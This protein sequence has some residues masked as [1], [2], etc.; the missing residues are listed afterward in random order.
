MRPT[1]LH[2]LCTTAATAV[3]LFLSATV[4]SAQA[5][6]AN[7]SPVSWVN[8]KLPEGPGLT[9]HVLASK[10]L[11]HD[12]GYVVWQPR[13]YD[14][15]RQYP[16]I[17]FLH[18]SSGTESSDAAGFSGW[19][20]KG[21]EKGLIPPVIVVFPNGGLSGYRGEVETMIIDELIPLIDQTR[22]T[23]GTAAARL[24]AG[25][26]MGGAGAAR[27]SLLHPTLFAAAAS[28]GGR[29]VTDLEPVAEETPRR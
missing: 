25:F 17:Y 14:A 24:I 18:G 13:D 10:A 19:V 28:L 29:E 11:G 21:I 15:A 20:A 6:A 22:P 12:V 16:V 3:V 5:G 27:L 8:P 7:S 1:L 26:S 23:V 4:L 2:S 9:H